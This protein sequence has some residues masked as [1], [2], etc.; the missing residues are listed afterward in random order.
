MELITTQ[1]TLAE[2]MPNTL[3]TVAGEKT[4]FEKVTIFLK[5]AEEWLAEHIADITLIQAAGEKAL[6]FAKAVVANEA[7]YHAIPS[8]DL[9]LTPNGFGIVAN[10][11]VSPA[12]KERVAN[13][14][15]EMLTARDN[16]IEMLLHVMADLPAWVDSKFGEFFGSTLFPWID[17]HLGQFTEDIAKLTMWDRYIYMRSRIMSIE[18][19]LEKSHFGPELMARLRLETLT[20]TLTTMHSKVVDLIHEATE[21]LLREKDHV[22]H[23]AAVGLRHAVD[24]I[25]KNPGD[26]TEWHNSSVRELWESPILYENKKENGG[27]FF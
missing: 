19:A 3:K 1:E 2:F 18:H 12:S 6:M 8:L 25:R 7:L 4:L 10:Q 26:F 17:T 5:G 24:I 16:N 22:G 9:V 20:G 21:H 14:R 27:Y 23:K 13:L 15:Q 11:N